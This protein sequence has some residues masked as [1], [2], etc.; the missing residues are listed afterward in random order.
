LIGAR[1]LQGFDGAGIMS[2]NAALVRRI[3]P[4]HQLG[5]GIG[6]NAVVVAV[7]TSLGPT[8]AAGILLVA[9]RPWLFA[10]NVPVGC[11][12]L[13]VAARVLPRT[14]TSPHSY[15]VT[16]AILNVLT[17]GLLIIGIDGLG[18]GERGSIV[19][20][21]LA[22]AALLRYVLV[23]RQLSRASPLLPVDLLRIPVFALSI[24]TSVCSFTAQMLAFVSLPFYLQ[25]VLGK[26]AVE[27]GLLMSPWPL[28]LVVVAP[29]AGRLA[30]RYPAGLLGGIGLVPLALGLLTLAVLPP[31]PTPLAIAWRM[32]L[33]GVGFGLFQTPNNRE[34]LNAAPK[35]RSGGASGMLGTAR[36]LG[37]TLGA[38]L[39]GLCLSMFADN[40]ATIALLVAAASSLAA[41]MAS[42]LRLSDRGSR[43]STH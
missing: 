32:A 26:S 21:E 17:F 29:I 4:I 31:D 3:Y 43:R 30:D 5:R 7:A 34:M 36:L 10:I 6:I 2:V 13:Y 41:A 39:V 22:A 11:L 42:S 18:R 16:S 40:G 19:G 15:D 20:V 14:P 24:G 8:I 25:D 9:D 38:A 1:V 27:T 35:G 23:R 33:C 12:T 37:Q 28:A